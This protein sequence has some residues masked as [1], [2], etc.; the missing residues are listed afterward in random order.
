MDVK[1]GR[2]VTQRLWRLLDN[3]YQIDISFPII[4]QSLEENLQWVLVEELLPPCAF[5]FRRHQY[6][7]LCCGWLVDVEGQYKFS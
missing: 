2:D 6:F 5:F 3:G 4:T 7:L 1:I